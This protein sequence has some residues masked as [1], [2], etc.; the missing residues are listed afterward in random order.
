ME[1][2]IISGPVT[3]IRRGWMP[4]KRGGQR[5]RRG[6]KAKKSSIEKIKRNETDAIKK[7][8]RVLNCNFR[9]GD[10]WLTLTFPGKE[11]IN[12]ETAQTAFDRV[13]PKAPRVVSEGTRGEHQVRLL[14]R[15]ER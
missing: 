12:W 10:L 3:E 7:L 8:T 9:M 11:E 1:Y 13:P 4:T 5:V 14:P 15:P 2:K 6:T